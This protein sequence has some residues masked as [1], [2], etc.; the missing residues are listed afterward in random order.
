LKTSGK[1][2]DKEELGKKIENSLGDC[3]LQKI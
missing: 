3:N 1:D 2:A